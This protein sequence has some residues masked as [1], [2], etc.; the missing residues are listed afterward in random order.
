MK[1]NWTYEHL[2]VNDVTID[3]NNPRIKRWL[4]MYGDEL[5]AEH[6]YLALGAGGAEP[7]GGGSTT[8]RSLREAIR[9]HGG[10]IHPIIVNREPSG[11]LL[12]IEGNTRVA[13]FRSFKEEGGNWET[14]PAIVHD[15]LSPEE[16]DAIRLQ[17]HLVGPRDWDAYSKAKYLYTLRH[18]HG[19]PMNQI[20]DYCGG[21]QKEVQNYIE[22]YIDMEKHYRDV[23]PDDTHFDTNR[24]SAFIELQKA[25]I[26]EA[27]IKH[28]F[29]MRD[30]ALWVHKRL[31]YPLNTVRQL[32]RILANDKSKKVFLKDGA[33]EALKVLE[34]PPSDAS[35]KD[36]TLE[37]LSRA[38]IDKITHV[39]WSDVKELKQNPDSAQA[40]SIFELKDE[41]Q[42]FCAEITE[43][44]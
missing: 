17:A 20:V 1:T 24:F 26:K 35:L 5:T 23:I 25:G 9:T 11:K 2:K 6:I 7:A 37:Q 22:A 10:L 16:I 34:A 19:L 28:R 36:A 41:L 8:F 21:R 15:N 33:R 38:L 39:Q 30:F 27:I 44:E 12:V 4:E 13:I 42:E 29:T 18:E 43:D 3:L 32:P 31:I 14:I 40:Q